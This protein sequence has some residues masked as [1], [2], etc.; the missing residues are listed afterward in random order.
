MSGETSKVSRPSGTVIA[1]ETDGAELP[2]IAVK[3]CAPA[4]WAKTR[5]RVLIVEE[6]SGRRFGILATD[7]TIQYLTNCLSILRELL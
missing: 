2:L 5:Q 3:S 6:R 4:L 1:V 7:E